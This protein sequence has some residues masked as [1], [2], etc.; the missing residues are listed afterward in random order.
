MEAEAR[1][2]AQALLN[3]G[4]HRYTEIFTI[5][6]RG[7]NS[8]EDVL[9]IAVRGDYREIRRLSESVKAVSGPSGIPCPFCNGTGKI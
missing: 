3:S 8:D 9:I 1:K 6:K 5:T 4:E 2:L 7:R